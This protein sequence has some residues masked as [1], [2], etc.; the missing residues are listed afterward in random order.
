VLNINN[1][2][3][4]L[5]FNTEEIDLSDNK[6]IGQLSINEK[7]IKTLGFEPLQKLVISLGEMRE[8]FGLRTLS[9]SKRQ[10]VKVPDGEFQSSGV[11]THTD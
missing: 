5:I 8:Y 2:N 6:S 9:L 3:D 1:D 7:F 11:S 4:F 10:T